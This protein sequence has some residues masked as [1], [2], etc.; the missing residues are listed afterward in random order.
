MYPFWG[1]LFN[2][3]HRFSLIAESVIIYRC[4]TVWRR[5][6]MIVFISAVFLVSSSVCGYVFAIST[7]SHL[8]RLIV[9]YF[10]MTFALNVC[11]SVLT[12]GRIYW[13]ARR[14]STVLDPDNPRRYYSIFSII[15]DSGAIYP[16]Y[17]L[18]DLVIKHTV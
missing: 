2:D 13:S 17:L 15:I 11:L 10:W 6:R 5:K 9:V 12:S 4:Y 3:R 1:S 16:T 18:L 7:S 8:H 14:A